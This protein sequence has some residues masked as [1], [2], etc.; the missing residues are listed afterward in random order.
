MLSSTPSPTP[1]SPMFVW[2]V[3][4]GKWPALDSLVAIV[5]QPAVRPKY[6]LKPSEGFPVHIL[7]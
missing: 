4:A 1:I 6:L 7:Q 5:L 2:F 3:L